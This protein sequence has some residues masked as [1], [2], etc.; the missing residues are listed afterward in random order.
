M[1]F[2]I[3]HYTNC[4]VLS[5]TTDKVYRCVLLHSKQMNLIEVQILKFSHENGEIDDDIKIRLSSTITDY[6]DTYFENVTSFEKY[7][8]C[9]KSAWQDQHGLWACK[10]LQLTVAMEIPCDHG[11]NMADTHTIRPKELLNQWPVFHSETDRTGH[12][13]GN[14]LEL[15][16]TNITTLGSKTEYFLVKMAA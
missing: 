12:L 8:R 6:L 10:Q 7:L 16:F 5:L 15:I 1:D 11:N 14:F 9:E 4:A 13:L 3:E 2:G